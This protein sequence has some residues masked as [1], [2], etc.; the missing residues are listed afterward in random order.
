MA[1]REGR[2]QGRPAAAVGYGGA[3]NRSSRRQRR[4][5]GA[6]RPARVHLPSLCHHRAAAR[7]ETGNQ[8]RE[9]KDGKKKKTNRRRA[10][11]LPRPRP[12]PPSRSAL[13]ARHP[14][15]GYANDI[16]TGRQPRPP[17]P[18][19][20]AGAHVHV[21]VPAREGARRVRRRTAPRQRGRCRALSGEGSSPRRRHPPH[22]QAWEGG[23]C[24]VASATARPGQTQ[25]VPSIRKQSLARGIPSRSAR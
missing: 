9:K 3:A 13:A 2:E 15:Q 12:P 21:R 16:A 17:P 18:R 25:R 7:N 8:R 24:D 22:R 5:T 19:G 23:A 14:E 6:T 4:G 20:R 10:A 1:G 11:P